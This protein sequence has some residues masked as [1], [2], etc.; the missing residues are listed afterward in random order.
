M[1]W[2]FFFFFLNRER[3]QAACS[4]DRKELFGQRETGQ[5]GF[6]SHQN[7]VKIISGNSRLFLSSLHPCVEFGNTQS[8]QS[9]ALSAVIEIMLHSLLVGMSVRMNTRLEAEAREYI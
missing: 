6:S 1:Y 2:R 9:A 4:H 8:A 5:R 3:V 7:Q